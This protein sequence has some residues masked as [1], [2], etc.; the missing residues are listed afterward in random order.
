MSNKFSS[1]DN[2]YMKIEKLF[3]I[4]ESILIF[5]LHT[6]YAN[7]NLRSA[8]IPSQASNGELK[9]SQIFDQ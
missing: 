3:C 2:L 4:D 6:G 7:R 9:I 8:N 5:R 1:Y